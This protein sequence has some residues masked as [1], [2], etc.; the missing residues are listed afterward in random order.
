MYRGVL[1][2][3]CW[4]RGVPLCTEVSSFQGVGIEEFQCILTSGCWNRGVSGVLISG[5][6]KRE[7]FHPEKSLSIAEDNL[8]IN[9]RNLH[10]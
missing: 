8:I 5:D 1:I 2:S 10:S 4:N 6:F 3:G 7:V 9:T